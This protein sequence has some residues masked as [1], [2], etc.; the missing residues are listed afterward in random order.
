MSRKLIL[1]ADDDHS[2]TAALALR[3][4]HLGADTRISPDGLHAYQVLLQETPDLVIL[5]VT[6]PGAGGLSMCE[7]LARDQRFAPLPVIILTGRTDD[8]TIDRCERLGAHY[9]WKGLDTWERLKPLIC[10]L[11]Q[12]QPDAAAGGPPLAAPTNRAP[13][14]RPVGAGPCVLVIDDDPD[15]G[16]AF[17]TRLGAQDIRVIRAQT[18]MQGFWMALKERPDAIITDYTMPDGYGDYIISRLKAHPLTHQTPLFVLTGKTVGGRRDFSLERELLGLGA[19]AVFIK[20]PDFSAIAGALRAE[21]RDSK[22]D[23]GGMPVC[24]P[25]AIPELLPSRDRQGAGA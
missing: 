6:M 18:G 1:I 11:L 20:P 19:S 17:Q 12:I 15:I 5:D 7:E 2:L 24:R 22:P 16:R 10:E 23:A 9:V 14:E 3:C 8:E 21:I 25:E 4:R 13:V